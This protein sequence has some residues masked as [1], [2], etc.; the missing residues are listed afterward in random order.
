MKDSRSGIVDWKILIAE[1][2]MAGVMDGGRTHDSAL[3]EKRFR[4]IGD[5]SMGQEKAFC[6][7]AMAVVSWS[8]REESGASIRIT[9]MSEGE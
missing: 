5:W 8:K 2:V 4:P 1:A 3:G 9:L 7:T 6:K